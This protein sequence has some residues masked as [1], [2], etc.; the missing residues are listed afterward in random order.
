MVEAIGEVGS[1]EEELAG[2]EGVSVKSG[3]G[4]ESVELVEVA[5][6]VAVAQ[7]EENRLEFAN[8]THH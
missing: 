4:G 1:E 6:G 8:V 7:C 5:E 2:D 3:L